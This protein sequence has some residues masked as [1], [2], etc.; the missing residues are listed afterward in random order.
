[1]KFRFAFASLLVLLVAGVAS[2]QGP[3]GVG[4]DIKPGKVAKVKTV[5]APKPAKLYTVPKSEPWYLNYG[6]GGPGPAGAGT[7]S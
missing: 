4:G 2:A 6:K 3:K 5:K 7:K 1:M